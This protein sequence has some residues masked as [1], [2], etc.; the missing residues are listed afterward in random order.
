MLERHDT[1]GIA[2]LRMNAPQRLNALSD[3]MLAALQTQI[4][5][6]KT[7]P[8]IRVVILS[9]AGKAFCAGHDLKEMQAGRA[10]DDKGRA[11]FIDL[12]QRCS[13]VMTGLQRLPQPVI[14]QVH[15]IA[16]AAGCQLVASCDMAVAAEDCKFGVNGVKIGLF[17][18]TPMVALSRNIPR[19][20]AFEMLT[21][22]RFLSAQQAEELGLINRAV[23]ADQLEQ[24]TQDLAETVASKLGAA[25]AI[26]KEAF[27]EQLQMP[28]DQ[29]YA[30]TGEVMVENMLWRDTN[31]GITAFLEKRKPDWD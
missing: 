27:Y 7:D 26:G 30:F 28:L 19:K 21:T 29:A 13:K 31:E 5:S 24:E 18:S 14:A 16:T 23:P 2:H 17:C 15:G 12:F 10:S 25:V 3:G 6:L 20:K 9:G 11:Y 8:S 4:D 22:G 1:N